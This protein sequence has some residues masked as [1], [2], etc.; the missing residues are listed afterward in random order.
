MLLANHIGNVD[1][2]RGAVAPQGNTLLVYVP[3]AH[4]RQRQGI[5]MWDLG[6]ECKTDQGI[7]RTDGSKFGP[8]SIIN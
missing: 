1:R 6:T 3:H 4:E 5:M 2:F 7:G 8:S